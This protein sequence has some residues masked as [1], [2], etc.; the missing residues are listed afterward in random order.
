MEKPNGRVHTPIKAV[1]DDWDR[2]DLTFAGR[3][4]RQVVDSPGYAFLEALIDALIEKQRQQIL[5]P[6][7]HE[8]AKYA[9]VL[10]HMAGLE[11]AKTAAQSL[12]YE[13]ESVAAE[14]NQEE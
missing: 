12:L 4:L 11:A 2:D 3:Q 5:P 14:R 10:G 9:Q 1:L 6:T 13:A 7:I 8:Q